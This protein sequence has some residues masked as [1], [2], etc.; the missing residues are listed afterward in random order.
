MEHDEA[1]AQHATERYLLNELSAGERDAFEDHFFDCPHCAED[2]RD[3]ARMMAAGREIAR[4]DRGATRET[5]TVHQL[6]PKSGW[7]SWIPQA[8]A[9]AV[10]GGTVGWFGAVQ[11]VVPR[12]AATAPVTR[13]AFG[14][15]QQLQLESGQERGPEGAPQKAVLGQLTEANFFITP[16]DPSATHYVVSIRDKAGKTWLTD[17][18]SSKAAEE[19]VEM[20]L[21]ELPGGEYRVVIESVRQGGNRFPVTEIPFDVVEEREEGSP[22]RRQP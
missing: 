3:G 6:R 13:P 9:A 21:P 5:A 7:T 20:L 18:V 14:V 2:V 22:T 8:A 12:A 15:I 1:I 17:D 4:T 16:P 10:I 11:T 19:P